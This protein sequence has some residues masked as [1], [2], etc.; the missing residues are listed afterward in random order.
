MRS[1][2]YSM[3]L[4]RMPFNLHINM[5][6]GL[7]LM[8]NHFTMSVLLTLHFRTC[9]VYYLVLLS[10]SHCLSKYFFEFFSCINA[11]KKLLPATRRT[12]TP[13]ITPEYCFTIILKLPALHFKERTST[14][15]PDIELSTSEMALDL[16]SSS[17]SFQ[18]LSA[19]EIF[20]F[21]QLTTT[22]SV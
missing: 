19:M 20:F 1:S 18:Y 12:H 17:K 5:C 2:N 13:S 10:F 22:Y 21:V 8:V 3:R 6:R 11:D 7:L 16:N 14:F 9:T 4:R 15:W